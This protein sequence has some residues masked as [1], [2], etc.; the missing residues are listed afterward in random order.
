[1]ADTSQFRERSVTFTRQEPRPMGLG[2]RL[3]SRPLR[4]LMTVGALVGRE[5]GKGETAQGVINRVGNIVASCVDSTGEAGPCI[6]FAAAATPSGGTAHTDTIQGILNVARNPANNVSALFALASATPP[7]QPMLSAA[8]ND[9]ML[10]VTY[11]GGGL[12]GVGVGGG[13]VGEGLL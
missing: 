5:V 2:E 6:A 11:S 3:Y 4:S 9:W 10:A 13:S 1:M 8:P 12:A 7:F